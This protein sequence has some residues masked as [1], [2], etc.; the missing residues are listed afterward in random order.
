MI[1]ESHLP[2][3]YI[4]LFQRVEKRVTSEMKPAS[5]GQ[6]W[7]GAELQSAL[8]RAG[9]QTASTIITTN[10]PLYEVFKTFM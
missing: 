8:G 6:L 9:T 10:N 5:D 1:I 4:V 7:A 2:S 3:M